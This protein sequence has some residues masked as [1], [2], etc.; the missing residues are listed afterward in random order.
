MNPKKLGK[1]DNHNQEPWKMPLSEFIEHLYEKRFGKTRPDEVLTIED[2]VRR[3][4][5]KK[6]RKRAA[7]SQRRLDE[8]NDPANRKEQ[9]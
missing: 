6:A 9:P 8:A 2:M 5:E 1:I 4:V 3:D 7:K